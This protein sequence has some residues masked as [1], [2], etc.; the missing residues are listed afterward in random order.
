MKAVILAAGL[1]TRLVPYSKEMPKEMLP[2]FVEEDGSLVLKPILQVVF[3]KLYEAGVREFCFVVGRGKRVVEDHFT[4]DQSYVEF[5]RGADKTIQAQMLERFY[6]ILNDSVIMWVNQP[7]P[8]GTGDAVLKAE[9]FVGDEVFIATAGDNVFLGENVFARLIELYRSL[10]A[11]LMT[12]RRVS[13]PSRYGVIEGEEVKE[14]IYRVRKLMEKLKRPPSNLANTSLY[15]FPPEIFGAIRRTKPS[16]RGEIEITDS[17]Q[18]LI[19]EGVE[20][21]AYES[22]ACW[23]D[24]GTPQTYLEALI[25]SIKASANRELL[26][27][28]IGL[29]RGPP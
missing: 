21:Y 1:G 15:I 28:L 14:G 9:H 10:G 3:E 26:E 24:V 19:N 17:I 22:K 2:I 16:P 23:I 13:N 25:H 18:L 12:V 8:K 11:P 20:F 4:P 6:E 27:Q 5:L 29:L 7:T